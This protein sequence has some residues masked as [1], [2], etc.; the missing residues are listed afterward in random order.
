[1]LDGLPS[2][3]LSQYV[4]VKK[5]RAEE[6]KS[7]DTSVGTY[8]SASTIFRLEGGTPEDVQPVKRLLRKRA[9]MGFPFTCWNSMSGRHD[10]LYIKKGSREIFT[11]SWK[12]YEAQSQSLVATPAPPLAADA[13]DA[14]VAREHSPV[15]RKA[16][17]KTTAFATVSPKAAALLS[18]APPTKRRKPGGDGDTGPKKP[19]T[20]THS[21][22]SRTFRQACKAKAQCNNVTTA[23][24]NLVQQI[25][26]DPAW[27]WARN[28]AMLEPLTASLTALEAAIGEFA[29]VFLSRD[30]VDCKKKFQADKL[31]VECSQLA[32]TLDPLVQCVQVETQQL[33][34]MHSSRV[35]AI[36]KIGK[37]K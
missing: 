22:A 16:A 9:Q 24:A 21:L 8:E 5:Q 31:I 35:S 18:A 27:K 30:I 26:N 4:A 37:S 15:N 14:A 13:S 19:K 23:A 6:W 32:L 7:I 10:F 3:Q 28:A 12:M 2:E 20:A 25:N 1:M 36:Q 33:L 29:R 11:R 17:R 34:S